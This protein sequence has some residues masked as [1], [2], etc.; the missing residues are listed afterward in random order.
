MGG[1]EKAR[2]ACVRGNE[3]NSGAEPGSEVND[4]LALGAA[5]YIQY[6]CVWADIQTT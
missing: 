5:G 1:D 3:E 2:L 4:D 6:V